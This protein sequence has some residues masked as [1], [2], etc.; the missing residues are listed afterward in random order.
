MEGVEGGEG[1]GG[2]AEW[3][4][5]GSRRRG[6]TRNA[7][8]PEDLKKMENEREESRDFEGF[9]EK[10]VEAQL[11]MVKIA[12][13]KIL[14]RQERIEK[15]NNELRK[16]FQELK[17]EN[18]ELRERCAEY[19]RKFKE[20]SDKIKI[21]RA[22]E[23]GEDKVE[24]LRNEWKVEREAEKNSFREIVKNQIQEGIQEQTR[25]AVVKIIKEKENLVRDTVEKKKC[26]VIYGLKEKKNDV[27]TERERE[28]KES[29]KKVVAKVQD[30]E[31]GLEGEIEEVVRL[32]RYNEE[33]VR[34]IKV[35]MRS[36]AAV[37]EIMLRTGRLASTL[38]YERVW[39]KR[40]MNEE[41]RKKEKDL[42]EEAREKNLNRTENEAKE[43]YWRVVDMKLR[44]WYIRER[45]AV[46]RG[47]QH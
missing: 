38:E 12:M 14:E 21:E 44:K 17:G 6:R 47:Q 1:R 11:K 2:E 35:R 13:E 25:K 27:R 23:G 45:G 36:Q 4:M 26:M 31:Q 46:G 10:E 15:E 9:D 39:I 33:K 37:E 40:D 43:F 34:P 16:N 8:P 7:R 19:E 30:E 24:E 3:S 32:G 20:L 5:A 41:E 29:V 22:M 28:L 18:G 42:R